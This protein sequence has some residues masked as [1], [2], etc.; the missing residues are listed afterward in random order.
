MSASPTPTPQNISNKWAWNMLRRLLKWDEYKPTEQGASPRIWALT[1][2]L[3]PLAHLIYSKWDLAQMVLLATDAGSNERSRLSPRQI[4]DVMNELRQYDQE[5]IPLPSFWLLP[6]VYH[7]H[8]HY[9]RVWTN[10]KII[11]NVKRGRDLTLVSCCTIALSQC[12]FSPHEV[13][14]F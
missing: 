11:E 12:P 9:L 3:W 14:V 2:I 8:R 6:P 4:W 13:K 7:H 5:Q 1:K 10:R